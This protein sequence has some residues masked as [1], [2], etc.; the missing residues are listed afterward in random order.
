MLSTICKFCM[1][2]KEKFNIDLATMRNTIS[3]T[4]LIGLRKCLDN[5]VFKES[6]HVMISGFGVG[7]SWGGTILSI[8][9]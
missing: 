8:T 4:I 1:L 5:D 3:S 6:H 2:S 7:L 9:H